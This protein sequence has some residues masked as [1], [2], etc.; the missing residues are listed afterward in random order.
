MSTPGPAPIFRRSAPIYPFYAFPIMNS[1]LRANLTRKLAWLVAL[2]ILLCLFSVDAAAAP[3]HGE[4]VSSLTEM[5]SRQQAPD[6]IMNAA[7]RTFWALATMGLVWNMGVLLLRRG[8]F[9]ELFLELIRFIIF[10]GLFYWLLIESSSDKGFVYKLIDSFARMGDLQTP[11]SIAQRG[12]NIIQLGLHIFYKVLQESQNWSDADILVAS[13]LSLAILTALTLLV[14]QLA[15]VVIMAWML[16]YA[17]IFLLGLGGTRW[18]SPAAI[19]FYKNVLALGA[20]LMFLALLTKFGYGFLSQQADAV[21]NGSAGGAGLD[22]VPLADMFVVSL[23][24]SVLGM[25]VP[26]LIYKTVTGSPLGLLGGTAS[27]AGNAF[28]AGGSHVY[29]TAYTSISHYRNGGGSRGSAEPSPTT[30]GGSGGAASAIDA[31]RGANTSASMEDVIFTPMNPNTQSG[32]EQASGSV[33]SQPATH[34]AW[35]GAR[36]A[37]SAASSVQNHS[38]APLDQAQAQGRQS[39]QVREEKAASAIQS[40][41][42]KPA[43]AHSESTLRQFQSAQSLQS[44]HSFQAQRPGQSPGAAALSQDATLSPKPSIQQA[45]SST[46]QASTQAAMPALGQQGQDKAPLGLTHAK[47]DLLAGNVKLSSMPQHATMPSGGFQ[48]EAL[49][50]QKQATQSPTNQ[51]D[52]RQANVTHQSANIGST[53]SDSSGSGSLSSSGTLAG[54]ESM[55]GIASPKTSSNQVSPQALPA[56][57]QNPLAP[58]SGSTQ[59]TNMTEQ[60]GK[61]TAKVKRNMASRLPSADMPEA[62]RSLPAD[63]GQPATPASDDEVAAF[64]DRHL[65]NPEGD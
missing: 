19:G 35:S 58:P 36:N 18:T 50:G 5:F 53:K 14:A 24:L 52:M 3:R 48:P 61:L 42:P 55:P 9:G 41:T 60:V 64:R 29:T 34:Q 65:S 59:G 2:L 28:S 57:T 4:L 39:S 22:Y 20:S 51:P 11:E 44:D 37:T 63:R 13:G 27:L 17:G 45:I 31:I 47:P 15:L 62:A 23:L 25:K 43:V 46:G 10:T 30:G 49:S 7:K 21:L 8:D 33:F 12:D 26:G 54:K 6:L 40:S 56:P 16:A 1:L 38:Q 32:T